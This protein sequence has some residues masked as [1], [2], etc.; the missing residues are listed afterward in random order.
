MRL[1]DLNKTWS[2]ELK[3]LEFAAGYLHA[4]L[5]DNDLDTFLVALRDI[6][7]ANGTIAKTAQQAE[8]GSES[9][10]KTLFLE[11]NLEFST[12]QAVFKSIGLQFS[13]TAD[14]GGLE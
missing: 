1:K 5:K 2:N 12:L 9:R 6:V 10:F 14:L 8:L 7:Q 4:T 13:V 3:D 11:G